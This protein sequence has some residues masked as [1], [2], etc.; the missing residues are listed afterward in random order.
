MFFPKVHIAGQV[1][2]PEGS[3]AEDYFVGMKLAG[4]GFRTGFIEN[5][6]ERQVVRRDAKGR[7]ISRKNITER[8]AVRENFPRRFFQAVR[9]KARGRSEHRDLHL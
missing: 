8:V 3:L 1:P 7:E 6:V 5:P 9:Q 4:M 2:F